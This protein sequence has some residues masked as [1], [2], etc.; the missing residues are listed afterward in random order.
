[1]STCGTNDPRSFLPEIAVV[2]GIAGVLA[3]RRAGR[4][5]SGMW[6]VFWTAV[7]AVTYGV[8][9]VGSWWWYRLAAAPDARFGLTT[10]IGLAAGVVGLLL[11]VF[12]PLYW[13]SYPGRTSTGGDDEDAE[14]RSP[15]SDEVADAVAAGRLG[16]AR[17]LERTVVDSQVVGDGVTQPKIALRVAVQL[18]HGPVFGAVVHK[19]VRRPELSAWRRGTVHE[20]LRLDDGA[21]VFVGGRMTPQQR[22]SIRTPSP[23]A[24]P[25][26]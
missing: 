14:V 1:V 2:F 9:V 20:V 6:P 13:P 25:E 26:R 24:T 15:T 7:G 12:L 5:A 11:V 8:A 18:L 22:A 16:V 19:W 3:L 4:G 17:V 10:W 21:V 23:T